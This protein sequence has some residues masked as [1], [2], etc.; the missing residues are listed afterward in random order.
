M[1]EYAVNCEV[2]PRDCCPGTKRRGREANH[3]PPSRAEVKRGGVVKRSCL[4][5]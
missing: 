3:P 2:I 5:S 4:P 1:N